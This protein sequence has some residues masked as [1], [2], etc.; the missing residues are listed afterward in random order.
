[1]RIIEASYD[2]HDWLDGGNVTIQAL[3]SAFLWSA[4]HGNFFWYG[5][6]FIRERVEERMLTEFSEFRRTNQEIKGKRD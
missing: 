6:V 4:R 5:S 2:V 1:M 3:A